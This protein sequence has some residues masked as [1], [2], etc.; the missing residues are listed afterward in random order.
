M[1]DVITHARK[2]TDITAHSGCE[3]MPMDSIESV[4]TAIFLGADAAEVDVRRSARGLV[5]SHNKQEEARY[6]SSVTLGQVFQTIALGKIKINCD[7]K[8][9]DILPDVLEL[10]ARHSFRKERLTITG[11][12]YP[13]YLEAHPEIADGAQIALNIEQVL[14]EYLIETLGNEQRKTENAIKIRKEPW[15][16]VMPLAEKL[17][18]YTG[19]LVETC[20]KLGIAALNIPVKLITPARIKRFHAL[21]LPLSIWTVNDERQMKEMLEAGVSNITTLRVKEAIRIRNV[22]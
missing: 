5:L 11:S 19:R 6:A 3:G 21:N 18:D 13:P 12:V 2:L 7:I 1:N 17:D 15:N 20:H 14:A 22:V 16:Y 9:A 8:E 4:Q 10:A